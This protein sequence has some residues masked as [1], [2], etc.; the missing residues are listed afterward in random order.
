MSQ[1][2]YAQV[3]YYVDALL[4]RRWIAVATAAVVAII[5]WAYVATLADF[6]QASAKIYVDT[7]TVLRTLLRGMTVETDM[8]HQVEIMHRS[9]ITRP[10]L[11][12][13]ARMV[14][15]DLRASTPVEQ[16]EMI[17]ELRTSISI[18]S[19]QANIFQV[20]YEGP[21]AEQTKRVVD[22]LTTLF[23]EQ[24][25]GKD[26]S[27]FEKAQNFLD[28]QINEYREK[29]DEI[30]A[31]I[32]EVKLREDALIPG[33]QP[34]E[35]QIALLRQKVT[36]LRAKLQADT[37]RRDVL[38]RELAE[39]PERFA[40][41]RP[42]LEEM[43]PEQRRIEELQKMLDELQLRYTDK[44]PD[45]IILKR[46]L[47]TMRAEEEAR[48]KAAGENGSA[49]LPGTSNP[50]YSNLQ[51]SLVATKSEIEITSKQLAEAETMLKDLQDKREQ[52]MGTKVE[53]TRLQRELDLFRGKYGSLRERSELAQISAQQ[54]AQGDSINFRMIEPPV[55]PTAPAGP[56]RAIL[57]SGIMVFSIAL[58]VGVCWLLAL[59]KTSY[60]SIQHLRRDFDFPV[61]GN[62]SRLQT[63]GFA[64]KLGHVG[65]AGAV[66][67]FLLAYG[68]VMMIEQEVGL[69]SIFSQSLQNTPI[70][71][72]IGR[73][74]GMAT[75]VSL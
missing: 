28:R 22:A 16:T 41:A 1:D 50:V 6:Y 36:E 44:H 27:D 51:V 21:Q 49:A 38:V 75:S 2:L 35:E 69:N 31:Q 70:S 39:T 26:R 57:A 63:G 73:I 74:I 72:F 66:C 14:D 9:L 43:S 23:V 13:V 7:S 62:I 60:G 10:N 4:R 47:E 8:R 55:V 19:D 24:N 65:F 59:L 48:A 61:V 25:I 37:T 58:G 32:D 46:R 17:E 68:G 71:E 5:G 45:V 52:V 12:E 3:I 67:T 33:P 42:V 29:I 56:N 34:Y 30:Q 54:Q 40:D 11:E 53:L 64:R 18:K 20:S 15:L